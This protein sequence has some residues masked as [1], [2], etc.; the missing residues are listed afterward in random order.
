MAYRIKATWPISH[1]KLTRPN[2]HD[3]LTTEWFPNLTDACVS[4]ASMMPKSTQLLTAFALGEMVGSETDSDQFD[5]T[6]LTIEE[7]S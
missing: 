6:T 3:E 7:S 2:S 4:F 1:D 5:I